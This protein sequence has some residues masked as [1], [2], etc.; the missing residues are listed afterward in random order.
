MVLLD[1]LAGD[2]G[3]ERQFSSP[4]QLLDGLEPI[5][6]LRVAVACGL[7]GIGDEI[8]VL[9]SKRVHAGAGREIVRLLGTAVEQDV[10]WYRLLV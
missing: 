6:T 4:T 9:L 2:A 3:D 10:Q 5:P 1:N 8:G 7:C